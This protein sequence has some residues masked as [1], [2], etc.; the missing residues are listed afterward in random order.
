MM[1]E[2]TLAQDVLDSIAAGDLDDRIDEVYSV[3]QQRRSVVKGQRRADETFLPGDRIRIRRDAA[4]APKYMLGTEY[5]VARVNRKTVT[6][7]RIP[8]DRT[9]YGKFAGM[10]YTRIPIDC[11]EKIS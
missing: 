10:P 1:I 11:I 6:T 2:D 4:I 9:V 7:G 5:T 8:A 3:V